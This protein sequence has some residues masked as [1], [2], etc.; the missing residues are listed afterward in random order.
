MRLGFWG[1]RADRGGLGAQTSEIVRHLQPER[2]LVVDLLDKG[3]GTSHLARFPDA[4]LHQGPGHLIPGATADKFLDG[5]DVALCVETTYTDD[6]CQR[7]RK[8]GV[9]TVLV[10]NP[11]LW[12][13][14]HAHPDVVWAATDW[15]LGRLPSRTRVVPHPVA[16]DRLVFRQRTSATT[17]VHI[18]APAFHDR[19]GTRL[20][21]SA[22]RRVRSPAR[23]LIRGQSRPPRQLGGVAIAGLLSDVDDYWD[24][25]PDDGDVLVLPRRYAGLSLPM[26]EAAA[27]GM[28]IITMDL[29]PQNE[30]VPRDGLVAPVPRARR[31]R[32][33]GG[34][35]DVHDCSPAY[36]A[37]T[38]ELF[39]SSPEVVA[40][41]STAVGEWAAAHSWD[42]LLPLWLAELEAAC[43]GDGAPAPAVEKGP[44]LLP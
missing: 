21:L 5:L 35:F 12:K 44:G 36:L 10:A 40:R 39:L 20:V 31:V 19:N 38:I 34:V 16:T 22:C 18:A 29:A 24:A 7:A 13:A 17:L 30:W 41:C 9:R 23:L 8:A 1:A 37:S 4:M 2:T 14:D 28:P 32:M 3:R 27:L 33:V 43:S 6:F 42:A 11:E 26:Q 15:E 25:W